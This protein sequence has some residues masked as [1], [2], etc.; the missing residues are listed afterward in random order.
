MRAASPPEPVK[1]NADE[2]RERRQ[3]HDVEPAQHGREPDQAQQDH[4]DR[5]EAT[6][7]NDDDAG[8]PIF[9]EAVVSRTGVRLNYDPSP[10]PRAAP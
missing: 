3:E 10:A 8:Q 7:R 2:K 6:Q 1:G 9:D 5:G 4:Q